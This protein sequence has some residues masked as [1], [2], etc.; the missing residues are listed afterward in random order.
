MK[1]SKLQR[2]L[3]KELKQIDRVDTHLIKMKDVYDDLIALV[4]EGSNAARTATIKYEYMK[5]VLQAKRVQHLAKIQQL[6][7]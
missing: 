3:D 4:D 1:K 5:Q 7:A 6:R 2:K